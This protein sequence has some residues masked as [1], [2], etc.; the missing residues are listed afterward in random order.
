MLQTP[1]RQH[2]KQA[3][4]ELQRRHRVLNLIGRELTGASDREYLLR[5][6]VSYLRNDLAYEG[7]RIVLKNDSDEADTSSG[8]LFALG[9][10]RPETVAVRLGNRTLA[11]IILPVDRG[12]KL[13]DA[14]RE[15]LKTFATFL[16]VGIRNV[17]RLDE[18][19]A[20]ASLDP[21]TGVMNRRRL[22][23]IG[24]RRRR[25]LSP[26]EST[27]LLVFDVDR[28]KAVNDSFGH[29]AGD[30]LLKSI[31][32]RAKACI[33]K[34]DFLA[35][36]GGD[37][38]VVLLLRTDRRSVSKVAERIRTY[39]EST[40]LAWKGQSI[41]STVSVGFACAD[42]DVNLD[43]LISRADAALYEAKHGGRNLV[44]S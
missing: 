14:D 40:S 34:T 36:Y 25:R 23:E 29:L 10:P 24:P 19:R 22:L 6:A 37:E 26:G 4:V 32:E 16:A 12:T 17:I 2:D 39:I 20:L 35:R 42:G 5:R 33:R 18:A 31:A 41:R 27:G 8:C 15:T 9:S 21:L 30:A 13:T 38:F 3:L 28:L 1:E 44:R 7:A 11:S 43:E